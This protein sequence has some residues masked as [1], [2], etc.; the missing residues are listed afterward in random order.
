[1]KNEIHEQE[2][3][4]EHNQMKYCKGGSQSRKEIIESM[5][6]ELLKIRDGI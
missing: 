3:I 1:M 2:I 5:E 6:N 4:D